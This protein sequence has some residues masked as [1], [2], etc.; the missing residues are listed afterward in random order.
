MHTAA[1]IA[2]ELDNLLSA[3]ETS[4]D[5][6]E[7]DESDSDDD[8]SCEESGL[9]LLARFAA[10]ALPVSSAPSNLLHDGKHCSRQSTL[11]K[12]RRHKMTCT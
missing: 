3:A 8:S 12:T 4:E 11:G 7:E 2:S 9:G 10:S 5:E 6:E 1:V